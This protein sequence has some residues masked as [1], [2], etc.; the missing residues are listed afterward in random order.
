V[1]NTR[2]QVLLTSARA[3]ASEQPVAL[4]ADG[5]EALMLAFLDGEPR[6]FERLFRMISPRV[7]SALTHMSGDARLA[8]D[9]TQTVFLK[10]YRARA[11]YQRGMLVMPWVFAIARNTYLDHRRRARRRPESLS[12]DGML[13]EP[14]ALETA[15]DGAGFEH[16][17]ERALDD[18]LRTLPP[19]Q[20]EVLVL[21]KVQ[22]LSLAEAAALCGTS[23]ASIKM[24][25][26][27]AYRSLRAALATKEER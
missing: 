12:A 20:R 10:L 25:A 27:R 19:A 18:L 24:R 21:L 5:P 14:A 1:S 3:A 6:A 4:A 2:L 7:A 8:E 16:A 23:P 9:L 26:H 13:P 17:E 11:A 22:G 15:S